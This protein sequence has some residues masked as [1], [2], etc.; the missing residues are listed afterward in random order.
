VAG[1]AS[2][3]G[4]GAGAAAHPLLWPGLSLLAGIGLADRWPGLQP[5][6]AWCLAAAG[7]G[8]AAWLWWGPARGR[9]RLPLLALVCLV[10]GAGLLAWQ[11]AQPLPP[12]HLRGRA[13]N[14]PR[15]L[16][17]QVVGA[18]QPGGQGLR[19]L[20]R[21]ESLD[22]QPVA[23][24]LTLSLPGDAPEPV[25]GHRLAARV[26]LKPVV[27]FANPGSFDYAAFM[28]QQDLYVQAFAGK[29][30][31]L[32]DL[33][34]GPGGWRIR[35]EAARQDLGRAFDRLGRG[36]AAGLLRALVLGQRGGL[37]P[38][39]RQAFAA[40]GTAHL[41]AISGLHLGLVWGWSYLVLRLLLAAWPALALRWG[42]LKPAAA[43]ALVPALG[44]SLLAG[45]ST[46]T[47]RALVMAA[48]LVAALLAERPY[49]PAGGLALAALVIGLLWPE[50]PL[51]LSFQLS[52][53]AVAAILL[54]A[55]PLARRLTGQRGWRR[56]LGGLAGWLALS[57]LVALAT[58]PL[59]ARHFHQIPWL[60]VP[61]NAL[62]IP[63]VAMIA[64]PL[65]LVGTGLAWVWPAAGDWL[66]HLAAWPAGA[67]LAVIKWL[68]GL[69][70]AVSFVAGPGPWAVA[71]L[72]AAAL[73]GLC[74]ARPWRWRAGAALAALALTV[75]WAEARPPD[76]DGRLRVWVLDVGQGSATVA[77]LPD[78]RV[79]VVDAGGGRGAVDTG[80]AVVAPF[81]WSLGLGRA[82]FLACSHSHPDHSG[83]MPFLARWLD[84]AEVWHN[85]EPPNSG[86]YGQLLELAG[87]G[88]A[89]LLGPGELAGRSELGGARLRVAWPPP[90]SEGWRLSENNRS[91]WI[92]LGLGD[93]WLWLPGDNGPGIERRVLPELPRGGEQILVAAHHGGKGSCGAELLAALAPR[94]VVISAGCANGF[95]MPR[96]EVRARVEASGAVL[97]WTG[98]SG[99]LEL[100]SDGQRWSVRPWLTEGR[101][102][103]W[104]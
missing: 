40:T 46:P 47:L 87:Q 58:W 74:L 8:L 88:G 100:T 4:S 92:G 77:R 18:P 5:L 41:L 95:G 71:L 91:L 80:Q 79:L 65:A 33:G 75:W 97:Y 57:A 82:D 36:E 98:I 59:A 62:A 21:A 56:W 37:E 89:A 96:P 31:D 93:T 102:C 28:A 3:G 11:R 34:A 15:E 60:S 85:G 2:R 45:G 67:G 84:P 53:T 43:L 24:L 44:Y 26:K 54:A 55:A 19:L 101:A 104:P 39:T 13:D 25:V 42:A 73:A 50:A 23:G 14:T 35:L 69:P 27:G 90:G 16:V 9:R 63:L 32:R 76:P 10:L 17:A 30:A 72:Y 70:G 81:L 7:L 103:P 94:A 83:G 64:L 78:G 61:A 68:A 12:D 86:P 49:R 22:G 29:R 52:F 48:C 99:C 20:A 38:A 66:L 51:T 1:G 6:A